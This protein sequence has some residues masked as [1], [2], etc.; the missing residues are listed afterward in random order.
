MQKLRVFISSTME[1]L[2]DERVALVK[3]INQNTFWEAVYAESFVARSESPREVCLDEVRKSHIYIGI[4][5]DRYGYIPENN[6]PRGVSAV[7]LE[8]KEAKDNQL[9]IIILIYKNAS[10]RESQLDEFLKEITDFDKGHWRREYTTID[11]LVQIAIESINYELTRAAVEKIEAKRRE[12]ARNIY[13]LPYF[14]S[15]MEKFLK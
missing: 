4:F 11:E 12:Q 10:N 5:K 7:V 3:V 14:K 1:D 9:P 8:Y 2:K 15:T 6:N 13:S